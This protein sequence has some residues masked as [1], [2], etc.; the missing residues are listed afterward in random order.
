MALELIS[1]QE[2]AMHLGVTAR[3][4]RQLLAD[5]VLRAA[6]TRPILLD[7][8]DVEHLAHVQS[9]SAG[10]QMTPSKAWD[11]I[12][13]FDLDDFANEGEL[14]TWRRKMRPRANWLSRYIHRSA[15]PELVQSP[16]VVRSGLR[17]AAF[18]GVPVEPDEQRFIGYA[19]ARDVDQIPDGVPVEGGRGWNVQLGI[20]PDDSWRFG[21]SAMF[22]DPVTAW[23]DLED[24]RHRSARLVLEVVLAS[25][26]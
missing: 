8:A 5:G 16:L 25:R 17:A 15:M 14:D 18:H 3:R 7:L 24:N 22:V 19:S 1:A 2:A 20:V 11:A 23:L 26:D 4:V 12:S 13:A 21:R 9:R 10:R 6:S